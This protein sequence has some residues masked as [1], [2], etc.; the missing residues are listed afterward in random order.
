M[1]SLE[2]MVR[3]HHGDPG[4]HRQAGDEIAAA[5]DPGAQ[6]HGL[7]P[8]LVIPSPSIAAAMTKNSTWNVPAKSSAFTNSAQ[9]IESPAKVSTR[10]RVSN[11]RRG[12]RVTD[13]HHWEKAVSRLG[14]GSRVELA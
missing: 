2:G 11:G 14:L 10:S 6:I 12:G 13:G 8:Q 7:L 3:H 4:R 5:I 1:A 9:T